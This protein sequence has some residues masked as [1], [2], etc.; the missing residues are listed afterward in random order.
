MKNILFLIT[1]ILWILGLIAYWKE[2]D[3][4]AATLFMLALIV[5]DYRNY[6][7]EKL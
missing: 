1:Y 3:K 6:K 7:L 5:C 4:I 2:S